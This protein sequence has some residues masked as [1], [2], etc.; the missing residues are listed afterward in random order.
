MIIDASKIEDIL[1]RIK[2]RDP[3]LFAAVQKKILQIAEMDVVSILHFKN[4]RGSMSHLKRV[5]VGS[6]ILTFQVRGDT[7]LFE[8]FIHHDEAYR[9]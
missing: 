1:H 6:F 4:L 3:A 7:I 5:Q 8:D 2:R 9:R